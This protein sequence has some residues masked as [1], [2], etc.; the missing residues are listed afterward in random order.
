M[1]QKILKIRSNSCNGR[2]CVRR[3]LPSAALSC[4]LSGSILLTGCN[5]IDSDRIPNYAVNIN[6]TPQASW[7]TYGVTYFGQYKRF[8]RELREPSNFQWLERT[9]TGFGGVLLVCGI[10]A[11]TNEANV[12]LAYDLACPVECRRDVRVK[13]V[14]AEGHPFPVAQCPVCKS[15]YDVFEAGGRP[16]SGKAEAEGYGLRIY[17]CVPPAN[18]MGGYIITNQ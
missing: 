10:D 6:L 1:N 2:W 16:I 17:Y 4:L 14:E 11:F 7:Q 15:E 3:L 12:P 9:M 5:T 13:M 8:V 18:G